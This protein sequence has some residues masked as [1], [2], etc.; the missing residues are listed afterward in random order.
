MDSISYTDI[1][2]FD[3]NIF[4][5]KRILKEQTL[6]LFSF[7]EDRK[8]FKDISLLLDSTLS[9]YYEGYGY[10]D[11]PDLNKQKTPFLNSVIL[12]TNGPYDLSINIH[13]FAFNDTSK[14]DSL[15][16]E[17]IDT[18][19]YYKVTRITA[20]FHQD[21]VPAMEICVANGFG[22]I[23]MVTKKSFNFIIMELN[24]FNISDISNIT[25]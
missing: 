3:S 6:K 12:Y 22:I 4:L 25:V 1:N 20:F 19:I 23:N 16:K 24:I 14:G 13:I 21:E 15:L 2:N 18:A 9:N 11:P 7:I 17:L 5:I 10:F 8:I